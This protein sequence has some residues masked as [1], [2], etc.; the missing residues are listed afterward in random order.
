MY[1]SFRHAIERAVLRRRE[2]K[3]QAADF[4]C[5]EAAR[6]KRL[7]ELSLEQV[8]ALLIR[9]AMARYEG[10]VS[11]AANALWAQTAAR[12]TGGSTVMASPDGESSAYSGRRPRRR[13][14]N[15]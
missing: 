3:I 5:G 1:A 8:E 10:N 9:K 7:E 13:W 12:C 15:V 6:R 4:G 11:K 14:L 2:I